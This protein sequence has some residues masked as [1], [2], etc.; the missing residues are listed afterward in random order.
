MV[1]LK[2]NDLSPSPPLSLSV[3]ISVSMSFSLS[4]SI[5]FVWPFFL[6]PSLTVPTFASFLKEVDSPYEVHDYVRA[7]LGD[8]PQAKDFAKQ[9]LERRAKQNVNQQKS[10]P[11]QQP[12]NQQVCAAQTS[13]DW[14]AMF[15]EFS[16]RL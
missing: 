14:G 7:Y 8:T 6:S 9:F 13:Q 5:L 11:S 1:T 12:K 16:I 15:E 2:L 10:L 4:L 3:S